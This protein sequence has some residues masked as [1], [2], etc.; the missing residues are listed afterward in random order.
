M[1]IQKLQNFVIIPI[2]LYKILW[3]FWCSVLLFSHV[4]HFLSW[5]QALP[6]TGITIEWREAAASLHSIDEFAKWRMRRERYGF[7]AVFLQS[8]SDRRMQYASLYVSWYAE[9]RERTFS[10]YTLLTLRRLFDF[11]CR[12]KSS[13]DVLLLPRKYSSLP[14]EANYCAT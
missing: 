3:Q 6:C 7:L 1:Y 9:T 12:T 4:H 2:A 5:F 13:S 10:P 8:L 14:Q 11:F